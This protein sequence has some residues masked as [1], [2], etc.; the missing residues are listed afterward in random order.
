MFPNCL[1][2]KIKTNYSKIIRGIGGKSNIIRCSSCGLFRWKAPKEY[3][4]IP[5]QEE[6]KPG[7]KNYFEVKTEQVENYHRD[8]QSIKVI[9]LS[10][11]ISNLVDKP[12]NLLDV[13]CG[14]GHLIGAIR[15]IRPDWRLSGLEVNPSYASF[16]KERGFHVFQGEFENV[17]PNS[18]LFDIVVLADVLEHLEDPSNALHKC[19]SILKPNG[20]LFLTVPNLHS[21][22]YFLKGKKSSLS[23]PYMHL[24]FFT[25]KSLPN[26]LYKHGFSIHRC[27]TRSFVGSDKSL[28]ALVIK[29]SSIVLDYLGLGVSIFL[30]GKKINPVT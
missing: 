26:L 9:Y 29:N 11:L 27:F 25:M 19:C 30:I 18:S 17:L 3:E 10:E 1:C 4:K 22:Y 8:I 20:Y 15:A 7:G 28:K 12:A 5:I 13:G 16:V 24:W 2:G 21:V 6:Y 14:L 23:I